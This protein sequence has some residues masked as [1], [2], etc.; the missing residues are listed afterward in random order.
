MMLCSVRTSDLRV[1]NSGP[2]CH[3]VRYRVDVCK[4]V[5]TGDRHS[6]CPTYIES[7]RWLSDEIGVC[8]GKFAK[9]NE[10]KQTPGPLFTSSTTRAEESHPGRGA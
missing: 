3:M 8:F 4:K 10:W 9:C 2:L 7:P 6:R 5:V 1:V